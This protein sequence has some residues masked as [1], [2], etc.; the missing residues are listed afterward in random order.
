[1]DL[2]EDNEGQFKKDKANES[3]TIKM[4]ID[5]KKNSKILLNF[6][7]KICVR[8]SEMK[9]KYDCSIKFK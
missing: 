8:K 2:I 6:F 1:M 7:Q 9:V 3:I 4:L 5:M